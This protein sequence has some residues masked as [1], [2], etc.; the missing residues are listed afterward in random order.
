MA[1]IIITNPVLN[2]VCLGELR[3]SNA[4]EKFIPAMSS[5]Q[6]FKSSNSASL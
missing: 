1:I 2:E 6:E 5:L 3:L 4:N